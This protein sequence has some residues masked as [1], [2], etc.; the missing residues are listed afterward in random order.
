MKR[1]AFILGLILLAG[2]FEAFA[3]SEEDLIRTKLAEAEANL[4]QLEKQPS[5]F[6]FGY[7]FQ[8]SKTKTIGTDALQTGLRGTWW[9][10]ASWIRTLELTPEQRKK[11]DDA[12]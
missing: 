6:S 3:Q 2:C 8:N 10:E 12:F 1:T 4:A 9:R 7:S 5:P 11:M